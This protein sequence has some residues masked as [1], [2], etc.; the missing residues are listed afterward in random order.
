MKKNINYPFFKVHING[1]INSEDFKNLRKFYS[2][3]LGSN[4]ILLYEYLKDLGS[5][6]NNEFGFY[7]YDSLTYLLNM[8]IEKINEARIKLESV[9][10]LSTMVDELDRKTVFIIEK[11]L[12]RNSV[13]KNAFIGNQLIK[14]M[15]KMNF[16]HLLGKEKSIIINKARHL[17]DISAKFEDVFIS[18]DSPYDLEEVNSNLTETKEINKYIQEKIQ[19]DT[20]KYSNLY[21]SILKDD[22]RVFYSRMIGEEPSSNIVTLIKE[23]RNNDFN[24]PC[25]NLVFYYAFEANGKINSLYAEKIIQSLIDNKIIKFE[26]VEKYLDDIAS[27]KCKNFVNKKQ[28]Y[29][30]IYVQNINTN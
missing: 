25:I 3:I 10:L 16:E 22:S 23:S 28:L 30:A 9:S 21:E 1:H 26:T 17:V 15:G 2:P 5:A 14:I 24:D 6:D 27:K 18:D 19:F 8:E 11:P 12:D 13:K 20:F 4:A 7:D 29:K